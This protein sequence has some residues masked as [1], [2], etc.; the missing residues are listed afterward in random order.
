M[1]TD[2]KHYTIWGRT[3]LNRSFFPKKKNL[4][5]VVALYHKHPGRSSIFLFKS[6]VLFALYLVGEIMTYVTHK[7]S[8]RQTKLIGEVSVYNICLKGYIALIADFGKRI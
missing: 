8:G 6:Y 3:A 2:G 7:P 4:P 5:E 1:E